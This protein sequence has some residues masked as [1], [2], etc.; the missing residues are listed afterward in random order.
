MCHRRA[1]LHELR[2]A[3]AWAHEL[4]L[5][6]ALP[7]PTR[8]YAERMTARGSQT[9]GLE[10][11]MTRTA[12]SS[13]AL[14]GER[15]D[16]VAVPL[17]IVV[18]YDFSDQGDLALEEAVTLGAA[19]PP[20]TI[21]IVGVLSHGGHGLGG[22]APFHHIRFQEA[23]SMQLEMAQRIEA[24]LA[25]RGASGMRAFIHCRIGRP[26]GEILGLAE[27][28]RADLIVVGTHGRRGFERLVIGSVAEE[29][30]RAASCPVL[31]MRPSRYRATG[32]P[33]E[34]Y[35]E[36][37]C[38]ACVDRRFATGGAAWWCEAHD[39]AWVQPHRYA[40]TDAGISRLRPDDWTLW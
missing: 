33:S 26:A 28:S 13:S 36:P 2:A 14:D 16:R 34:A 15:D 5:R 11:S 12:R 8:R 29:V 27:E 24:L 40:Y 37:P 4:R 25:R 38:P 18:G 1:P 7:R 30:V 6:R 3:R 23:E 21:H 20:S 39:H 10:A 22:T 9:P 35:P 31:V 19:A 17:T 32:K